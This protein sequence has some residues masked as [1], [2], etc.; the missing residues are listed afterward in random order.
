MGERKKRTTAVALTVA[1]G[2]FSAV[3]A[4]ACH[5][6]TGWCCNEIGSRYYC[7]YWQNNQIQSQTCG[8]L[9]PQ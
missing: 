6:P 3:P 2:L 1:F 4:H 7:C 8:W 5:E 9:D